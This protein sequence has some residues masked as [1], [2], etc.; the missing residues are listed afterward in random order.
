MDGTR[1]AQCKQQLH[2][3]IAR[4]KNHPSTIMWNVA[5]ESMGGPPLGMGIPPPKAVEAGMR[6][7][8][9]CMRRRTGWM[10]RVR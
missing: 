5:N 4:D 6:F 10:E 8:A 1:L 3:L 2:E 9:S 7:F